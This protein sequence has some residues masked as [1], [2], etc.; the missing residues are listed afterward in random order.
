MLAQLAP[1]SKEE[2]NQIQEAGLD[3]DKIMTCDDMV[4][5]EQIFFAITAITNTRLLRGMQYHS[6]HATTHSLLIR[7]E[8]GTRR[9]IR[10][11]HSARI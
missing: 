10:A 4:A 11:E 8:T 6:T 9:F 5:S 1:Q 3:E 7:A 2:R